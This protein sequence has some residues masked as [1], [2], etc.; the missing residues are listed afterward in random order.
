MMRKDQMFPQEKKYIR[1]QDAFYFCNLMVSS[2][3]HDS[4]EAK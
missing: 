4:Y 3:R 2:Y 1:N